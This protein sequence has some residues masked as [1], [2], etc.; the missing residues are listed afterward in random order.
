MLGLKMPD[1]MPDHRRELILSSGNPEHSLEY[2]DL[3]ARQHEGVRLRLGKDLNLPAAWILTRGH[4]QPPC[5]F[6][7]LPLSSGIL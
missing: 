2:A 1:F 6:R 5:D 3:A 4:E 7:H